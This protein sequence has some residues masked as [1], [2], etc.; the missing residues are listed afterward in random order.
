[1]VVNLQDSRAKQWRVQE[2]AVSLDKFEI[3]KP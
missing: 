3:R 2:V 1:M